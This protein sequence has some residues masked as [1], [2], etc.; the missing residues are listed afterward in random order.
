M[1]TP[2]IAFTTSRSPSPSAADHPLLPSPGLFFVPN[3]PSLFGG[4]LGN[5]RLAAGGNPR[6]RAAGQ[7]VC[8]YFRPNGVGF[9]AGGE[10]QSVV[11]RTW[12]PRR[13]L[14]PHPNTPAH[15]RGEPKMTKLSARIPKPYSKRTGNGGRPPRCAAGGPDRTVIFSSRR[16]PG[17]S[18]TGRPLHR[19]RTCRCARFP[20]RACSCG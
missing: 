11:I 18:R 15:A 8:S 14:D 6:W 1:E 3:R 17:P 5:L 12:C 20:P 10:D 7:L 13:L 9:G 16:R 2:A 4:R 19:S